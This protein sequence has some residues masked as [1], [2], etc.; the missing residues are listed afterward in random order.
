MSFTGR[1]HRSVS[2]VISSSLSFAP[3]SG[4]LARSGRSPI[5]TLSQAAIRCREIGHCYQVG[6]N[7]LALAL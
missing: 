1:F 4:L 2:L 6:I 5:L 7:S 3:H